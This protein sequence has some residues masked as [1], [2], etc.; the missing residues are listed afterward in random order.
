MFIF[1]TL[2][3]FILV[4]GTRTSSC[5]NRI[6]FWNFIKLWTLKIRD[7]LWLSRVNW[8][9]NPQCISHLQLLI[10]QG[11][12]SDVCLLGKFCSWKGSTGKW[13]LLL[14]HVGCRACV[15]F[16][17]CM[18][19]SQ[20]GSYGIFLMSNPTVTLLLCPSACKTWTQIILKFK[21]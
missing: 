10:E 5:T 1:R 17:T 2:P 14:R 18:N 15:H 11:N 4:S 6:Y 8:M 12:I 3:V 9:L 19:C 21:A 13:I 16:S 20:W 7:V